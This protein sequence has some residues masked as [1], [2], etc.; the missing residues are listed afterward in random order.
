MRG[1]RGSR[2]RRPRLWLA[3]LLL[4]RPAAAGAELPNILANPG[5]ED[6]G[7][8]GTPADWHAARLVPAETLLSDPAYDTA[9]PLR[10][11]DLEELEPNGFFRAVAI[12]RLGGLP[13]LDQQRM[14]L[15][16]EQVNDLRKGARPGFVEIAVDE[17]VAHHGTRSLRMSIADS[18]RARDWADV[19]LGLGALPPDADYLVTFW[20]RTESGSRLTLDVF[21]RVGRQ[22]RHVAGVEPTD[23]QWR[24]AALPVHVAGDP[25][26]FQLDVWATCEGKGNSG[27]V[28]VDDVAVLKRRDVWAR[29]SWTTTTDTHHGG[30][31]ALELSRTPDA[32]AIEGTADLPVNASKPYRC[33][34][35]VKGDGATG[36]NRLEIVWLRS[37]ERNPTPGDVTG[38]SASEKLSGTFDWRRVE[39]TDRPPPDTNLAMVRV[40]SSGNAG[41]LLVDD[42]DFDGLGAA[43][44]EVLF[45][46]AGY[47]PLGYKDVVVTTPEKLAQ[48]PT[49]RVIPRDGKA[50]L[51]VPLDDRGQGPFGH[52]Y[53]GGDFTKVSAPGDYALE[54]RAGTLV[55]TTPVFPI[56]AGLYLS[57]LDKASS[58]YRLQRCGDAVPG[59]HG[60]C[61]MDDAWLTD[62]KVT[63]RTKHLDLTGGWHDAGDMNKWVDGQ[64]DTVWML[65]RTSRR[66]K[67]LGPAAQATASRLADEAAW[68]AAFLLKT[69]AGDGKWYFAC[70]PT[71]DTRAP[72]DEETDGTPGTADDRVSNVVLPQPFATLALSEFAADLAGSHG[73]VA[74]DALRIAKEAFT[75]DLKELTF[76]LKHNW[77]PYTAALYGAPPSIALS[78]MNLHRATRDDSY[79]A[80]A[81][82]FVT[83]IADRTLARTYLD[84]GLPSKDLA[85]KV[86]FGQVT[87]H[88]ATAMEEFVAQYPRDAATPRVVQALGQL[89]D[90]LL[91]YSRNPP[92]DVTRP[93][94]TKIAGQIYSPARHQ[95]HVLAAA[96][97]LATTARLLKRP[98]LLTAAERDL[99]Y[100]WG[101]N[102]AGVS[103]MAKVGHVF[104][105]QFTFLMNDPGHEDGIMPGAVNKGHG[106]RLRGMEFPYAELPI[107]YRRPMTDGNQE[108]W[109]FCQNR[110][111]EA[112]TAV[113]EARRTR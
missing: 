98:E 48:A 37:W 89:A 82:Q 90:D 16:D 52:H 88:Y 62:W 29:G 58:W 22:V 63:A 43:P 41:R 28:W 11:P 75:F 85:A 93:V 86:Q 2:F 73:D 13:Q 96:A 108:V 112:V 70:K 59:W 81:R 54:V 3:V 55:E 26:P 106:Y 14:E 21:A 66:L 42:A 103:Q 60:Q 44:L 23:G 95:P 74:A 12:R 91:A 9:V 30:E 105:A 4:A 25:A 69:Y 45:S 32:M 72:T 64:G 84:L 99:Q 19:V 56:K 18:R 34:A 109:L 71:L 87:Y 39:V 104:G 80:V 31:R 83:N 33:S 8:D 35:W 67:A 5:F 49:V 17:R 40:V 76:R 110:F 77:G 101:R 46:Q 53:Y 15:S 1:V 51:D 102:F 65:A 27:A 113:L 24:R 6:V 10:N 79:L 111:L 78:A 61:H 36:V 20:Y 107:P 68:G 38:V 47:E 97:H 100:T 92:L 94:T 57:L 50:V 7:P